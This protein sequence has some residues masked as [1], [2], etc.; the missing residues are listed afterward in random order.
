MSFA[1]I[2]SR[3][4][5]ALGGLATVFAL[6]FVV[7]FTPGGQALAAHFLAQFR[8]ERFA[9][10]TLDSS[11]ASALAQLGRLGTVNSMHGQSEAVK[12]I[13]EASQRVGF[14]VKQPDPSVLPA[15]LDG[16]PR[17]QVVSA[18]QTRFTFDRD[19][20][21]AYFQSVGR[22][23]VSLPDKFHGA[24]LVASVPPAAILVYGESADSASSLVVGQSRALTIG[25]EGG[26][27][28]DELRDFLLG[29]P[30]LP[31]ETVRQLRAIQD[32]RNTLPIPVPVG[33]V[34][35]RET[36]IAGGPGLIL[37]DNSGL[38][39]GAIWH[40]DGQVYG[41]AGPFKAHEIQ[42]VADSLR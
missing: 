38:G 10:V 41:L 2:A 22:P 16:T 6:A 29:L 3:R 32:W 40:R 19:K 21:R 36:T 8:G 14:S 15:G 37:G 33:H 23:D 26:A 12:T 13:T 1:R 18:H 30:G 4:R 27:T 31:P 28:L 17:I 5:M 25:A 24:T 11:Q 35:W 39:S 34:N 20:A 42:R 7:G 9:V